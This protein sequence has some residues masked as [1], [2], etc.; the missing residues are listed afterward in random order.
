M[1]ADALEYPWIDL[2][3][4]QIARLS[5]GWDYEVFLYDNSHL[6]AHRR[7][8]SEFEHVRV[9]P[10]NSVAILGRLANRVGKSSRRL[11]SYLGRAFERQHPDAL[12]HL[13]RKV[14][15]DFDYV[16][17]L[18][19]DSFP[20][21]ADWLDVLI[22]ACEGGAT[23]AGVHRDEMAPA[24]QPFIHVS[25]LCI[26]RSDLRGLKLSFGPARQ[27]SPWDRGSD[28]RDFALAF[29][30]RFGYSGAHIDDEYNQDVGQKI[31]YQLL[32]SGRTIGP[33]ERSNKVNFH[34]LMGGIYGD[35][36]YHHGAG[37]RRAKIRTQ[38]DI[39]ADEQIRDTLRDVVF[40]DLDHLVSVLRG[41][42]TPDIGLAPI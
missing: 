32:R 24:L 1:E 42:V 39:D 4:R 29:G 22:S 14:P 40:R 30:H 23:V 12:D 19:N 17:T 25:C 13:A 7:L 3:L 10:R 38:A 8:A 31:T 28:L 9:L 11:N 18:D 21:R 20:I 16:V 41:E 36:I 34:F 15:A 5:E 33:L 35:V 27:P 6:K 37:S 2:C 26:S